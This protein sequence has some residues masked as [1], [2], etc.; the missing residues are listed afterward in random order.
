M[1]TLGSLNLPAYYGKQTNLL[2]SLSYTYWKIQNL[3]HFPKYSL[4]WWGH[5]KGFRI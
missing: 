5:G 3:S 1:L 4:G 2:S